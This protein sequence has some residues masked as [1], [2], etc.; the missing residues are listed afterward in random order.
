MWKE[1]KP[2]REREMDGYPRYEGRGGEEVHGVHVHGVDAQGVRV[3][4]PAYS[5]AEY[6]GYA[7]GV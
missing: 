2:E 5:R 6:L 4:P 3:P 1:E 7:G